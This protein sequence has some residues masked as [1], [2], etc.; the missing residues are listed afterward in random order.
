[1]LSPFHSEKMLIYINGK[2]AHVQLN[3]LKQR[4]KLHVTHIEH[5]SINII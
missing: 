1:M 5:G 3:K 4:I 2:G